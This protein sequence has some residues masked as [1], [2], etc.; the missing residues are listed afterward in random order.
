MPFVHVGFGNFVQPGRVV[1]MALT[2]AAPIR[3]MVQDAR[4]K[5]ALVDLTSGR[6]TKG[7]LVTDTG[8]VIL[9][10]LMPETLVAR[11]QGPVQEGEEGQP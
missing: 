4:E 1:A 8:Q 7:V 2:N 9:V 6:R 11:T 3:R 5:G 10:G